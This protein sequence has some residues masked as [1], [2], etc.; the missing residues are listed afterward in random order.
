[1]A[2]ITMNNRI[3]SVSSL[4]ISNLTPTQICS[5]LAANSLQLSALTVRD[6]GSST[7]SIPFSPQCVMAV[8]VLLAQSQQSLKKLTLYNICQELRLDALPMF[9]NLKELHLRIHS[10]QMLVL[11]G[12][13]ISSFPKL[14]KI[15]LD[16]L[17]GKITPKLIREYF[18][19]VDKSPWE[20]VD[21]LEL[22]SYCD[23]DAMKSL[24]EIFPRVSY[25]VLNYHT[26][27]KIKREPNDV[28]LLEAFPLLSKLH[29]RNFPFRCDLMDTFLTGIPPKIAS[30]LREVSKQ[31]L[32]PEMMQNLRG[33]GSIVQLKSKGNLCPNSS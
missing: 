28:W 15:R 30:G 5:E 27:G 16:S 18:S 8:R 20:A 22:D 13:S 33:Q 3:G 10:K 32:S 21:V 29:I 19:G 26:W 4:T 12:S 6:F 23:A 24:A 11:H 7:T 9:T 1:M 17:N 14:K 25:V 31:A 2:A